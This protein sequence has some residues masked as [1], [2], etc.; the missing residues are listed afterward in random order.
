MIESN[1][2]R[3]RVL[4]DLL[5]SLVFAVMP[6]SVSSAGGFAHAPD[7]VEHWPR[8][9]VRAVQLELQGRGFN[10]GSIDGLYG[11]ATRRAILGYQQAE[12]LL[13]DGRISDALIQ[14]LNL[15]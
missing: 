11:P 7:S 1:R 12:G 15:D 4:A 14:S 10:P 2:E 5:G 3:R 9:L 6:I 13:E 8:N